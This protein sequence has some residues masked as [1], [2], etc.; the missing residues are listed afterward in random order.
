MEKQNEIK[1][2]VE[3]EEVILTVDEAK[4]LWIEED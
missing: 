2:K 1:I 4:K 3:G